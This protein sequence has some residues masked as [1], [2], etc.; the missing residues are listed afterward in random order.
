[1]PVLNELEANSEFPGEPTVIE[2]WCRFA[3]CAVA[4][5]KALS[6]PKLVASIQIEVALLARVAAPAVDVLLAITGPGW[7]ALLAQA[8]VHVA[9]ADVRLGSGRGHHC[10]S[11]DRKS[12][13]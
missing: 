7:V 10:C 11:G 5:T 6:A 2:A 12:V 13:V 8:S 3:L 4:K 9:G 1:M